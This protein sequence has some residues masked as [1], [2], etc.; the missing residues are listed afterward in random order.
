V[1]EVHVEL[2]SLSAPRQTVDHLVTKDSASV[3]GLRVPDD[4]ALLDGENAKCF[5]QLR[6]PV[7]LSSG[8]PYRDTAD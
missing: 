6:Y 7:R 3:M 8:R 4:R 5:R 2:G 1:E